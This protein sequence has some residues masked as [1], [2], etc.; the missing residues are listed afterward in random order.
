[1]DCIWTFVKPCSKDFT[2]E[3][4]QDFLKF[5]SKNMRP[6]RNWWYHKAPHLCTPNNIKTI[7]QSLFGGCCHR[8]ILQKFSFLYAHSQS[9]LMSLHFFTTSVLL[10]LFRIKESHIN[11][12][13]LTLNK[14]LW[15]EMQIKNHF[16]D[17]SNGMKAIKLLDHHQIFKLMPAQHLT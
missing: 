14:L 8:R 6:P 3:P 15:I 7:N 1:M 17:N 4:Q 13:G 12:L 5:L 9:Q 16:G 2:K 10:S 11:D